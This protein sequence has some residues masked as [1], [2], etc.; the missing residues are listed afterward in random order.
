MLKSEKLKHCSGCCDDFYNGNN[1][2]GVNECW[3]LKTAKMVTQFRI[4]TWTKPDEPYAFT[5]VNKLNCWQ[6]KGQHF[7]EKLPSFV[8]KSKVGNE[9][10]TR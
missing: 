4:G 6:Q 10:K 3:G 5:Q 2:M 9:V 7:Y 8:D 1:P